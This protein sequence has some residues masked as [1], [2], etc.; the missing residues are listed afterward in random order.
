MHKSEGELSFHF[1]KTCERPQK[2]VLSV[3]SRSAACRCVYPHPSAGGASCADVGVLG[4][5]PAVIGH[6]QA[7]EVLKLVGGFGQVLS[8]TLVMYDARTCSFHRFKARLEPRVHLQ[9]K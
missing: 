5:V 6:L 7:L 3:L 8:G 1:D 2:F 9:N 4:P